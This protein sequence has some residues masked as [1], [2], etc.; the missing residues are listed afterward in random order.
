MYLNLHFNFSHIIVFLLNSPVWAEEN[1]C[2]KYEAINVPLCHC[3][4]VVNLA[5]CNMFISRFN[6][7]AS[8]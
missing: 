8:V 1:H 5:R 7:N 4:V 6:S 2:F 3:G